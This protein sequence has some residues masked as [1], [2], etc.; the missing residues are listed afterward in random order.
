MGMG[1][2]LPH[3]FQEALQLARRIL[4]R[5]PELVQKNLV[6]VEAELIVCAAYRSTTGKSLSRMDLFS[7]MQDAFPAAAGQRLIEWAILR[8]EGRLLQHLFGYQQFLDHEYE[9]GPEV[10]VP[11][12]ETEL[13]V[14]TAID[15]LKKTEPP[16][17][18]LEVGVGSGVISIELL[19]AFSGLRML[20]SELM[21][22]ARECA[23]RNARKVAVE[24]PGLSA[25][26]EVLQVAAST[27]VLEPFKL[28]MG[29]EKA[30]FL[31][32]NPPYLSKVNEVEAEVALHEPHEALF[33]PQ[34]DLLYF[35]RK[36]AES[37]ASLLKNQNSP[38][39]MEIPHERGPGLVELFD[40]FGWATQLVM[41]LNHRSRVLVA[42]KR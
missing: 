16:R 34:D 36:I 13:L 17:L 11:R 8:S 26:F 37:A 14:V 12:P 24:V 10:L 15:E 7:R 38:V 35:Y 21:P 25:R 30:D 1:N 23:L 6:D 3:G 41:D 39:F 4:S 5:S 18:G 29:D 28:A 9:V 27:D 19:C 31:I 32:S 2:E 33:A 22:E 40:R 42:R 20:G